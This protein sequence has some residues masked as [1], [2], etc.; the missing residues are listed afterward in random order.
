[1]TNKVKITE[2]PPTSLIALN[3]TVPSNLCGYDSPLSDLLLGNNR[4]LKG[5]LDISQCV[6]L[7][8]IDASNTNITGDV[9]AAT[10]YNKLHIARLS[11][12]GVTNITQL[13]AGGHITDLDLDYSAIKGPI[14]SVTTSLASLNSLSI[15]SDGISNNFVTVSPS[16]FC[17]ISPLHLKMKA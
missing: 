16:H 12:T 11:N 13:V 15:V 8:I 3:G 6:S 4:Q 10:G 9:T 7:F 1:M 14:P 2:N 5:N 17:S